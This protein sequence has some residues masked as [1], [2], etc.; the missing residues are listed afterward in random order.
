VCVDNGCIPNQKPVFV[1]EE[2]GVQ[3][4][5]DTG[6]ICLHHSCYIACD[7]EASNSC[8]EATGDMFPLCKSVTA[9]S[10][11][12]YVCGSSSNLGNQCDP[13]STPP[14]NCTNPDICIDGYCR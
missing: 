6:S 7:P 11:V 14:L 2:D 9:S 4:A 1:C 5:C 10:V 13:T 12:Y 3:G 8:P